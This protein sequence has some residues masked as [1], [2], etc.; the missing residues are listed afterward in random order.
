MRVYQAVARIQELVT[1]LE[2]CNDEHQPLI[3]EVFIIPLQVP[4]FYIYLYTV[5]Y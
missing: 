2:E 1:G 3:N 5:F 4:I